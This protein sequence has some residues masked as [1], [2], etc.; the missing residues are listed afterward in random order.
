VRLEPKSQQV[1]RLLAEPPRNLP[2]GEYWTRLVVTG[3]GGVLPVAGGDSV[4]KAGVS[5]VIRLVASVTYRKGHVST[6]VKIAGLSADAEGDSLTVWA[7]M[8]REGNA[9]YLG[10]ADVELE[11]AGGEVL[12]SWS[13]PLA[14]YYPMRRRFTFPLD[15]I[16]PGDYRVRFRLRTERPDLPADR[17]LNAPTVSDSVAVRVG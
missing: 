14:V 7:H 4:V 2:D 6:G 17:V 3:R 16:A 5:L 8:D 1:V 9:A 12:R 15:S 11:A 13:T 10:T